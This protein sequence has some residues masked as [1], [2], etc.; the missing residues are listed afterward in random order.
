MSVGR[1]ALKVKNWKAGIAEFALAVAAKPADADANNLLGYSY[2]KSGD[3]TNAFKFYS[4]A[5][6]ID[7]KHTGALEY[8]GEAFVMAGKPA[9]AK[10]NLAKLQAIC[11]T[12]CE[13]YKDLAAFIA[14]PPKKK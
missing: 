14:K 6:S 12:S 8:Q 1:A 2:R 5:L 11:G 7:P 13:Q 9:Q 3:L 4:I 10:A